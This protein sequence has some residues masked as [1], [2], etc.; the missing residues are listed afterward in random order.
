MNY[1]E[2][3][4]ASNSVFYRVYQLHQT[5]DSSKRYRRDLFNYEQAKEKESYLKKIKCP[6][7]GRDTTG[8][9]EREERS[10]KPSL[11][12][13]ED[14][15]QH[16]ERRQGQVKFDQRLMQRVLVLNHESNWEDSINHNLAEIVKE[17]TNTDNYA[18]EL[19]G[20]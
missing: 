10:E 11:V 15:A 16:G 18:T 4:L 3:E 13:A 5:Y 7:L 6:V 2:E 1:K 9:A 8:R 17:I 19:D 12:G 20:Q 14:R